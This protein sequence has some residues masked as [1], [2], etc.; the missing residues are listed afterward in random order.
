MEVGIDDRDV[1]ERVLKTL[2]QLGAH[3]VVEQ[4]QVDLDG[5][6][7]A[8]RAGDH[9]VQGR[10]NLDPRLLTGNDRA[11][12]K[13]GD[14]RPDNFR[15]VETQCAA[16]R[17]NRAAHADGAPVMGFVLAVEVPEA[18]CKRGGVFR[19]ERKEILEE[20]IGAILV[21]KRQQSRIANVRLRWGQRADRSEKIIP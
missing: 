3:V 6:A 21:Q 8:L 2:L 13:E 18:E 9:G 16:A 5:G 11:V 12:D 20:R 7:L 1:C 10:A 14:V 4:G 17:A 15:H 19:R